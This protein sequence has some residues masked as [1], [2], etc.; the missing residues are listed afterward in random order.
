LTPFSLYASVNVGQ[1]HLDFI[2]TGC[3]DFPSC[4]A[5]GHDPF[6]ALHADPSWTPAP[7]GTPLDTTPAAELVANGGTSPVLELSGLVLVGLRVVGTGI[8]RRKHIMQPGR[9]SSRIP[10]DPI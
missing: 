1:S 10:A 4:S 6:S 9:S 7:P 3:T 8:L 5:T 2:F